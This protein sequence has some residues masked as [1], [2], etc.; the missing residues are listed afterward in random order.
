M[1]NSEEAYQAWLDAKADW[2][3]EE[4]ERISECDACGQMKNGCVMVPAC[5]MHPEANVCPECRGDSPENF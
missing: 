1:A 5:W 3:G 4:Y 2:E